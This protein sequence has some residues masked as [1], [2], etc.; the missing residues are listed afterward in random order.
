MVTP[1]RMQK[2]HDNTETLA[3]FFLDRA[4]DK[5][6]YVCPACGH[7]SGTAK[8]K[9]KNTGDGLT[10][11]GGRWHCFACDRKGDIVDLYQLKHGGIAFSQAVEELEAMLGVAPP[12]P[13]MVKKQEKSP[14]QVKAEFEKLAFSP[15]VDEYRGISPETL[16]RYGAK[17]CKDFRNPLK[18]GTIQ[19]PREAMTF[20]TAGGCYY[21]RALEHK[22][23]ER[24]DK[25]D[26]GGKM[27]FNVGALKQ[28]R[29]V[30]VVEG[31]IDALSIMEAGGEAVGV[32]GG[33]GIAPFV[34]AVKN[35]P[36]PNG[37][38]L[39]A[40]N[41]K[42][43]ASFNQQW[44]EEL[45]RAG[46]EC[47]VLDVAA[48]FA[49]AK[50]A[51]EA[52]QQDREG[53]THRIAEIYASEMQ[54]FN[55]WAAGTMELVESIESNSYEPIST[56]IE[57]LDKAL[58]GG[59]VARQ[60]VI[61]GAAPGMGK[62]AICQQIAESTGRSVL[63]F[64]FEMAREQLQARS[65]SR[66]MHGQGQDISPLDVMQG[67]LGWREGVKLY[68]KEIAGRVAYFGLG[69]GLHSSG[70]E[71]M[72]HIM[73]EGV[74]YN[75]SIGR[76]APLV[77]VDYLQLVDVQGQDEQA[78]LKTVMESL[79]EFA[80]KH[81]TV[82]VGIVANNRE[83]NKA[84][85]V[86][87]YAGRGSSSIEYGADIVL[88]LAYTDLLDNKKME[89]PADKKKRSLVLTKG[90][91]YKQDARADFEFNGRYSEFVP[92]NEWGNV[93]SKAESNTIDSLLQL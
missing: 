84:G 61:L 70:L 60:L 67:K 83:S 12:P 81:G 85:G 51:N 31:A 24:C 64:C 59:F 2:L 74:R 57:N 86:S 13:P 20:P 92:V 18:A 49:G 4:K 72:L 7:G 6:G 89:E 23:G 87:M 43:G 40:D 5:R 19:G 68:Q 10:F 8:K 48:L 44:K 15:L 66:L 38:L 46:I 73:R 53:L 16:S 28:G 3:P 1:E 30:M 79:K 75:A 36:S 35:S 69:S 25:W 37:I 71:E 26:I 21:V 41:D 76:P 52:L 77:F 42:A 45:E 11:K 29:P 34:E 62:T 9:D 65:I 91:F 39:A 27:P 55:P 33:G 32:C 80:V 78:A 63:Y 88:G 47:K 82:V 22:D 56:G 90:R 93:E 17:L 58:G 14:E 54:L 50:D